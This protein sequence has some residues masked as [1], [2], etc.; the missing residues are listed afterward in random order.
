MTKKNAL[1]LTVGVVAFGLT[2]ALR[3]QLQG[4]TLRAAITG[5]AFVVLAATIQFVRRPI[6]SK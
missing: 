6:A 1:A 2:M 5:M 4:A 3:A